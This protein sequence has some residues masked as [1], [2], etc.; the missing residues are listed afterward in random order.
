M[1]IEKVSSK[2]QFADILESKFCDSPSSIC[3][4]HITRFSNVPVIQ[5]VRE[6]ISDSG[7]QG[8]LPQF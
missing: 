4:T 5:R 7:I 8:I 3:G 1:C 6:R 2:A